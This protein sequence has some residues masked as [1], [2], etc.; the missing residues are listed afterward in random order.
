MTVRIPPFAVVPG[1]QV[2]QVLSGQ[3]EHVIAL[4]DAA[5]RV[6]G[7]GDTRQP[8][9]VLPALPRP[10]LLAHHRAAR[11]HRRA[12]QGRRHQMDLQLPGE[13]RGGHPA[14]LRRRRPQR[15]GHRLPDR[16]HGE[17]HHQRRAHRGLRRPGRRLLTKRA[18]PR[19]AASAS[20]APASSPAISTP[21]SHG[22][23]WTFDE[24][25]VHDLDQEH[26]ARLPARTWRA[27]APPGSH[28]PPRLGRGPD[29]APATWS[30]SRPSR[31]PRTSPTPAWFSHHPVVLH[32]SLRDLAPAVILASANIVDDIEHCLKADTSPHLAE[33]ADRQP[34]L[35]R[36]H[37]LRRHDRPVTAVPA[38]RTVV[39]SPFGLGV[40]D[41]AVEQVRLRP[42]R[43]RRA[44]SRSWTTSSTRPAAT[45]TTRR[46]RRGPAGGGAG[47]GHA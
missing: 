35:H 34:R 44:P 7:E 37:P 38:G 26:A 4:I 43:R 42:N 39:F 5:Y 46:R 14:R 30:C 11:L 6:H 31:A 15:P 40:L 19:R 23:G 24:M 10:S 21:I 20:S 29:Q 28:R 13:H 12:E 45:A 3:E 27:A 47:G 25:G 33:Q 1:S 9:V 18:R 16:L 17:L 8:A 2:H 41:L 32:V 36:R 22:T